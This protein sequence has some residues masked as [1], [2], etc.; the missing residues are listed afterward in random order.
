MGRGI[1]KG[2]AEKA[3]IASYD[4]LRACRLLLADVAGN[5]SDCP[6]NVAESEFIGDDSAP[7]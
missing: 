1:N 7:S 6:A 3:R 4:E 2:L 5:S